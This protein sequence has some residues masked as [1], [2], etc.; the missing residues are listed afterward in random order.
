MMMCQTHTYS[1]NK[2]NNNNKKR[3]AH[4]QSADSVTVSRP[5]CLLPAMEPELAMLDRHL[6]KTLEDSG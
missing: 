6:L 2:R 4:K 3:D 1:H 5:S